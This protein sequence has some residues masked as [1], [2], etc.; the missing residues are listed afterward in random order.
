[1]K[2]SKENL[3]F[4][5]SPLGSIPGD[6]DCALLDSVAKRGSGHT[7]NKKFETYYGG[8]IKW[9]S[10]ADS[11]KLDNGWITETTYQISNEGIENSS[12]VLHPKGTV[13]LS[14]DAGVGKSAV[15]GADMAVSQHFIAWRCGES[16]DN[17]FLYYTLQMRKE[18]FERIAFGSTIKTIGLPYFKKFKILLPPI[19]EQT[20]IAKLL[21]T[22]DKAIE[23]NNQLI[24]AKEQRKKWLMQQL[25]T[26][27]KRL[28]GFND[29]WGEVKMSDV[30]DRVARRNVELNSTVVTISAQRG[31]V[32]QGDYFNKIV[33]SDILDNY[34]LVHKGEFCYNKSYS[35]GY[36][37][38]ATKRL[39]DF[40]KAVV[41]T[42]YICF[43]IKDY[44]KNSGE[45]FE[46][47][48]ES[49]ILDEGLM[50][51]AHEG[52]RAHGLLNVTPTDFF[53]LKI[54]VPEIR[55]QIA[56]AS[57]LQTA[58]KEINLLK[59]KLEAYKEQKKG[60]MQVLLTGKVRLKNQQ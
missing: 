28:K 45:F 48:F 40:E 13:I 29:N 25:L 11:N 26:G 37:W 34:F 12:A 9:I 32:S 23:K 42:L 49:G 56:I 2:T 57:I 3:K 24:A 51:I 31:F 16:L 15:M 59:Q 22:W 4:K 54:T 35:N 60:L 7:P 53:N 20:S 47:F 17:W 36:P 43:G 5:P 58:D 1:M 14:R 55:E 41:T 18:E 10:L 21:L 19:F 6:W 52:G 46:H 50:K 8:D 30:F 38:G 33:A 44:K 27:K 39:N